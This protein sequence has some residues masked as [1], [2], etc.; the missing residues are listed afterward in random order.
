MRTWL[1]EVMVA[2]VRV[3]ADAIAQRINCNGATD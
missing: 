2:V 3:T 1:L